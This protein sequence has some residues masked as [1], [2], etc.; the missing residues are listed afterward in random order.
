VDVADQDTIADVMRK[1]DISLRT[2]A[3]AAGVTYQAVAQWRAGHALPRAEVR[4]AVASALGLSRAQLDEICSRM[5]AA[6]RAKRH[7][8]AKRWIPRPGNE[9]RRLRLEAG[10][11]QA[12]L[13]QH[14]GVPAYLVSQW[15]IGVR[16]PDRREREALARVLRVSPQDIRRAVSA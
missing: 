14:L 8:R 1:R 4:D 11:T 2:L 9:L 5:V 15:E 12:E 6:R 7:G 10:I 3:S 13:A 16:R